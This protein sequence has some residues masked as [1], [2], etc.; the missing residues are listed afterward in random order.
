MGLL[1]CSPT[2]IFKILSSRAAVTTQNK[3]MY[4]SLLQISMDT[5]R[6]LIFWDVSLAVRFE[7][8]K[9]VNLRSN[10]AVIT[11]NFAVSAFLIES[12]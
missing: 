2:E 6:I 3:Y 8:F 11:S 12:D 5:F 9:S 7:G 10:S 1:F 4:R